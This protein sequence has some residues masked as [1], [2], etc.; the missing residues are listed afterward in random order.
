MNSR[1]QKLL[2]SGWFWSHRLKMRIPQEIRTEYDWESW[3]RRNHMRMEWE[4]NREYP[5]KEAIWSDSHCFIHKPKQRLNYSYASEMKPIF[6]N[7]PNSSHHLNSHR[8]IHNKGFPSEIWQN[9]KT[10]SVFWL[11][12]LSVVCL[13]LHLMFFLYFYMIWWI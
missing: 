11:H 2:T 3:L 9:H 4:R 6:N 10:S 1:L 7:L 8:T 5:R 13:P 12:F